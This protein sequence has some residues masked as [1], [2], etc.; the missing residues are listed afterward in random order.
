MQSRQD[1]TRKGATAEFEPKG[2]QCRSMFYHQPFSNVSYFLLSV[3]PYHQPFSIAS[4]FLPSAIFYRQPFSAVSHSLSTA[5]FYRQPF[6]NVS[7]FLSSAFFYRKPF[8]IVSHFLTPDI[9]PL[10]ETF[11]VARD[12]SLCRR[13]LPMSD[14]FHHYSHFPLSVIFIVRDLQKSDIS[15]RQRYFL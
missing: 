8:S 11:S 4:H 14:I 2:T 5:I 1:K 6:T 7:L 13:R 10:W 9:L 15:H 12:I 3:I